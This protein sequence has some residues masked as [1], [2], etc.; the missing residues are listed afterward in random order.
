MK[1]RP[2]KETDKIWCIHGECFRY[3]NACI[4]CKKRMKCE[5]YRDY[6]EPKLL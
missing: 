3:V 5:S 4:A 6:L 2:V 1:D